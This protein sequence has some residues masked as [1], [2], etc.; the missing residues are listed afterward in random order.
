MRSQRSIEVKL[1]KSAA[2]AERRKR[3][4]MAGCSCSLACEMADFRRRSLER[5]IRKI[6]DSYPAVAA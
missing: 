6:V 5:R 3:A 2:R 4:H 1:A